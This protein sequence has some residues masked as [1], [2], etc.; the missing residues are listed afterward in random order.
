M[1]MPDAMDIHS[2]R[3]ESVQCITALNFVFLQRK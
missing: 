1:A 3:L 2:L